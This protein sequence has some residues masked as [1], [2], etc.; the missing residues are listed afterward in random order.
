MVLVVDTV[1]VAT[2]AIVEDF[3]D[4][5]VSLMRSHTINFFA[6][7]QAFELVLPAGIPF[8]SRDHTLELIFLQVVPPVPWVLRII[9]VM[10][11]VN[12]EVLVI[13]LP[14]VATITT[15]SISTFLSIW[16]KV[17]WPVSLIEDA[18]F[19][20]AAS[21]AAITTIGILLI[22]TMLAGVVGVWTTSECAFR[23]E[24]T[25]EVV[26]VIETVEVLAK[27]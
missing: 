11:L 10:C 18:V 8:I 9:L 24:V 2:G 12:I 1:A 7:V 5:S 25:G 15:I 26:R 19:G 23:V 27:F 13:V 6:T 3:L 4:V 16:I 14:P 22:W 21:I 17:G 20:T